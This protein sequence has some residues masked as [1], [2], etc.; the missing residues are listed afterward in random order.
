M[1]ITDLTDEEFAEYIE[2]IRSGELPDE[3]TDEAEE[4]TGNTE[5]MPESTEEM[6]ES[7]GENTESAG[8]I[9][10]NTEES[11]EEA[12]P[13]ADAAEVI[14][15]E[16]EAPEAA[17]AEPQ[18]EAGEDGRIT[19]L[20]RLARVKYPDEEEAAAV[21]RLLGDIEDE[22]AASRG[23][24]RED[25]INTADE[26]DEF[27]R[28][29]REKA[30]NT[31]MREK[32]AEKV[33]EWRADEERLKM[34]VPTFSLE[35]AMQNETFKKRVLDGESVFSVYAAMNPKREEK[36]APAAREEA[37]SA[38]RGSQNPKE[39]DPSKLPK[40]QFDEY[41]RRIKES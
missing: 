19:R 37:L 12:E 10:E 24:E 1:A 35:K 18:K 13:E 11:P 14:A 29:K 34:L 4:V 39:A 5:E 33:R 8:D 23:L 40:A 16:A 41:I 7:T 20:L 27:D 38:A 21:E 31:Q 26:A 25:F 36:A 6:P 22:E 15:P 30:E 17:R 2:G 9:P 3:S 32:A 28:W